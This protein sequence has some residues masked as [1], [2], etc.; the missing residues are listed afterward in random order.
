VVSTAVVEPCGYSHVSPDHSIGHLSVD[1]RDAE[2]S[3][4]VRS[5][6][7]ALLRSAYLL[8]GDQH[9]AEDLVQEALARTHRAWS[10]L[11]RS[12]NAEAYARKVMYHAQVSFWRRPRIGEVLPG[13]LDPDAGTGVDD[14]AE[15]AVQRLILRRALLALSPKQRAVIVL[16]FFEDHTEVEAA[17]LL[18]VSVSTVKTQT[19][20]AL[21][22]L[23][24]LLPD[25]GTLTT[26]AAEHH[27]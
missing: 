1:A 4:F 22:R 26:D 14:P 27:R 10:R 16:R 19:G 3:R 11:E 15:A 12:E 21:E 6:T 17:Q 18:G 9:L 7:H 5:R 2:Y 24:V 23:R 8:T 13:D 20:R 25:L